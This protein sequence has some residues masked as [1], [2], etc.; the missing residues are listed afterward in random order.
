MTSY[1]ATI[2]YLFNALPVF[3]HQGGSAYKPGLE[4]V[5]ELLS[6]CGNPHKE[7]KTIHIAGTNGK[8]ST[9]HMLASIL[10]SAG[11][12]V[13]LFTSPHLID[14]RERIRINGEMIPK[15]YVID[16]VE[17]IRLRIPEG[18][19]PSFF[20]LT[21]AMAF[22]YFAQADTDIAVIE[23][24]M[25]GRLDSTNV[26]S[27]LLSVITN[28]SIDHAT[29]LGG[30]LEAIASEKSGI[31]KPQTPVILGRSVEPEV[32]GVVTETATKNNA[33][34]TIAD[35]SGEIIH[36]QPN[37]DGSQDL[38][39]LHFGVIR[40]PL[41]GAYQVENT[42]T[43]LCACLRLIELGFPITPAYVKEGIATVARTGL[44]GRLQVVQDS[45]PRIILDTGHNPGAWVY[46][47]Q[48]LGEWASQ[49]PLLCLLGMAGDKDVSEVLTLLPKTNTHYICCKAKGERS[50]PAEQLLKAM[51]DKGFE[52]CESIPSIAQAYDVAVDRCIAQG[53]P[54]LFVGGSNFVIG[55]LLSERTFEGLVL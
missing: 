1:E 37:E 53:I 6:L 19:Q 41:G 33:P 21:T 43:V 7:L 13:G 39:T 51:Q 15:Q 32:F 55:E 40:Q 23:V 27:P 26:L 50:L 48:Q 45:S 22:S 10:Q 34:L 49:A 18:L 16:F 47:S 17:D 29:F 14:F 44:K 35:K 5:G 31:I 52:H 11:Y 8:G 3:Q 36:V 25:G 38:D 54:T 24:G 9:S 2:D 28:V 12:R 42:C 46:L 30:T 4:R 20:E